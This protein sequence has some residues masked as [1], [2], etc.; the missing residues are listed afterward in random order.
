M[1]RWVDRLL[2][3]QGVGATADLT[4]GQDFFDV[5]HLTVSGGKAQVLGRLRVVDSRRRGV[6]YARYGAFDVGLEL[7]GAKRDWKILRA[8][9][10]FESYPPF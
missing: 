5:S 2:N 8:K 7:K 4:V 3:I 6:L 1:L 9:E 10:W